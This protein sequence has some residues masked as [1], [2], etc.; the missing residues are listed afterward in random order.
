MND[1]QAV[2]GVDG[3]GHCAN[4]QDLVMQRQLRRQLVECLSIDKLHRDEGLS[5]HFTDF[6]HLADV[7]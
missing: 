6:V 3:F 5:F 1:S 2:G 7:F 4:Q